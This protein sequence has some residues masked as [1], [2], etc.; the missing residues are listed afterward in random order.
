MRVTENDPMPSHE[1]SLKRICKKEKILDN[2]LVLD[3]YAICTNKKSQAPF[4]DIEEILE[5]FDKADAIYWKSR[6]AIGGRVKYLEQLSKSAYMSA[7]IALG[8]PLKASLLFV[9]SL[10]SVAEKALEKYTPIDFSVETSGSGEID[11]DSFELSEALDQEISNMEAMGDSLEE[12]TTDMDIVEDEAAAAFLS[13]GEGIEPNTEQASLAGG[14]FT[15]QYDP[16]ATLARAV[17]QNGYK[18]PRDFPKFFEVF[19]AVCEDVGTAKLIEREAESQDVKGNRRMEEMR[20]LESVDPIEMASDT[21]E[22]RVANK[23]LDVDRTIEEEEGVS[24]LFVLL[25]VSASMLGTAAGGVKRSF[26]ADAITLALLKYAMDGKYKVWVVPFAGN[27][28]LRNIREATDKASALDAMRW[29]GTVSYSGMSTDI[30]AAIRYAYHEVSQVKEYNK[31]EIVLI[32]D[33]LS[34]INRSVITEKPKNTTL[35]TIFVTKV[36]KNEGGINSLDNLE[37]AS[38][39][40]VTLSWDGQNKRFKFGDTFKGLDSWSK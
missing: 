3:V 24:H 21:F 18:I 39:T 38:Q 31:C 5:D 14:E 37:E 15:Q 30:A 40:A 32:T 19:K 4:K 17:V 35:R 25:D 28:D 6:V 13:G 11:K 29:L 2:D 23:Q 33:G 12:E 34:V 20:E 7:L 16:S 26:A 10:K 36:N 27:V 1:E 8:D 9:D 22:V